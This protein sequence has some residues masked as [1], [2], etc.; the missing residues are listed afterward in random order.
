MKK[1]IILFI[2]I[3]SIVVIAMSMGWKNDDNVVIATSHSVVID[4]D[5]PIEDTMEYIFKSENITDFYDELFYELYKDRTD[6]LNRLDNLSS[7]GIVYKRGKIDEVSD[8][9]Y[10]HL[11]VIINSALN[12]IETYEAVEDPLTK[13]IV[14]YNLEFELEKIKNRSYSQIFSYMIRYHEYL[15][16]S[17]SSFAIN[18][19]ADVAILKAKIRDVSEKM[20]VLADQYKANEAK[21]HSLNREDLKMVK[22]SLYPSVSLPVRSSHLYYDIMRSITKINADEE[23]KQKY[24]DEIADVL[25]N[26]YKPA[27]TELYNTLDETTEAPDTYLGLA[28]IEGGPD[29]YEM[30]LKYHTSKDLEPA[31]IHEMGLEVVKVSRH[32]LDLALTEMSYEGDLESKMIQFNDDRSRMGYSTALED[33]TVIIEKVE[34][35]LPHW[36]DESI[37]DYT[38]VNL[39]TSDY[40]FSSYSNTWYFRKYIGWFNI[41]SRAELYKETFPVLVYHETL[42]GHHLERF[43]ELTQTNIP[44]LRKMFHHTAYIE[45]WASYAEQLV[46]EH[47]ISSPEERIDYLYGNVIKAAALVVDTG[48]HFYNW[49]KTTAEDYLMTESMQNKEDAKAR[50]RRY[51]SNPGQ[52]CSY[53]IGQKFINDLRT[54]TEL[55]LGDDF[56]LRE[57]HT[58]ILKNGS[59]PLHLL[60]QQ[61]E[62][63]IKKTKMSE[64]L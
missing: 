32:E 39:Y 36:F 64:S 41:S 43:N 63:Y 45:G 14:I 40:P 3:I 56:D 26:T 53:Y 33:T 7:Y 29:Y 5:M 51:V 10:D 11:L 57:F 49:D 58:Q 13:E 38:E 44:M 52:G 35:A 59:L 9:Y 42:P 28:L 50:V 60:E 55:E 8:D 21:G 22:D 6:S 46:V 34:E 20:Y 48:I 54:K 30:I 24:K 12:H 1:V 23:R 2:S 15:K 47:N 31:E 16:R 19:N 37:L 27:I 4:T 61:I 18:T 62:L 17:L 25:N